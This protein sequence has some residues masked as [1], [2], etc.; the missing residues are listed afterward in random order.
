MILSRR[1]E[2]NLLTDLDYNQV[3][4]KFNFLESKAFTRKNFIL[5]F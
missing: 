1:I 3:C 4:L 2:T 5:Q